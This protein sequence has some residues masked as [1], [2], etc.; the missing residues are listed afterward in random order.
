MSEEI[1]TVTTLEELTVLVPFFIEG[2]HAMNRK[3]KVFEMDVEG[4]VK[5]L[6]GVLNTPERNVIGV[7][8]DGEALVGYGVAFDDTPPFAEMKELLMWATYVRPQYGGHVIVMIVEGA[9]DFAR[10][11][12]YGMVK[13]YNSRFTGGMY[14]LFEHKLGMKRR[15]VQF[16][17]I[18]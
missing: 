17:T 11:H 13:A 7:V 14:R 2:Y 3:G 10:R 8:K 18:L 6:I 1:H 4:F 12:G 16:N 9:K 5:T 15:R